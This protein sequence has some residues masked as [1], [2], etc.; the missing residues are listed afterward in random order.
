METDLKAL[1][2]EYNLSG[3]QKL[4]LNAITLEPTAHIFS[5]SYLE[6]HRLSRGGVQ[7]SLRKL[8]SVQLVAKENGVWQVQPPRMRRWYRLVLERGQ[9]AAEDLRFS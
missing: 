6:R 7:S 8:M 9:A 1:L 2:Q 4:L 5:R 3:Q